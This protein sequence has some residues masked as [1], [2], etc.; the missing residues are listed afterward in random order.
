MLRYKTIA[1]IAFALWL[2]GNWL[3]MHGHFCF[4][5]QE[6][7]VSVHMHLDQGEHDHPADEVHQDTNLELSQLVPAKLSKIDLSLVLLATL[8]LLLAVFYRP[9]FNS[10]YQVR[11]LSR[12]AYWRPPLRAPPLSA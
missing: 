10:V 6:P 4:D 12:I 1:F 8:V 5:G 9:S 2:L 3:G 11:P 7:L